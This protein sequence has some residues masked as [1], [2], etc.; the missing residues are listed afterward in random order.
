M[1]QSSG[2]FSG[3]YTQYGAGG[4]GYFGA[5]ANSTGTFLYNP[6]RRGLNDRSFYWSPSAVF[7]FNIP[8]TGATGGQFEL[9]SVDTYDFGVTPDLGWYITEDLFKPYN[10]LEPTKSNSS[11]ILKTDLS[12]S[13]GNITYDTGSRQLYIT[14]SEDDMQ[15]LVYLNYGASLWSIRGKTTNGIYTQWISPKRFTSYYQLPES[16]I[17]VNNPI[18][19]THDRTVMLYGSKHD[20]INTVV[21]NG[22]TGLTRYP[23]QSAWQYD[24]VL[25]GGINTFFIKGISKGIETPYIYSK[26][27]LETGSINQH[28]VFNTFDDFGLT[29][30]LERIPYESNYSYKTRIKDVFN[31]PSDSNLLGLTNG[32]VRNLNLSYD[33]EALIIK[34]NQV[35]G[36]F[37]D[38]LYPNLSIT[39]DTNTIYIGSTA[40]KRYNEYH[41]VDPQDNS[42]TLTYTTNYIGI[43]SL[44]VYSSPD[45]VIAKDR[46]TVENNI[47]KLNEYVP[48]IWVTY[49]N[50]FEIS[51]LNKTVYQ[52]YT[53]LAAF[54][55]EDRQIFNI[56]TGYLSGSADGLL[57]STYEIRS[58]ARYI[59]ENEIEQYGVP[60]KWA[61]VCINKLTDTGY[62]N[63]YTGEFGDLLNSKIESFV[64]LFKNKSHIA[65]D[66]VVC[67]S[68][69]FDPIDEATESSSYI[70]SIMDPVKGFWKSTN[71]LDSNKI[72]TTKAV[73]MNFICDKDK[74]KLEY[75]GIKPSQFKSGIGDNDDLKV[76][77]NTYT[78]KEDILKPDIFRATVAKNA[79]GQI[80]EASYLPE[81]VW[82]S[83]LFES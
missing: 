14:L 76:V 60:I 65:F 30:G 19:T 55:Y 51:K 68:D 17:T 39:I 42:V 13:N 24:T 74:T 38:E 15:K 62:Q 26:V 45:S 41:K 18:Y 34:P 37:T 47:I 46:Y 49:N 27:T 43:N 57:K 80:N 63:R 12:V 33:D 59:D 66:T 1:S 64:I 79:T 67:D 83:I 56:Q 28:K 9:S 11:L 31:H 8:N 54:S 32:I 53:G 44:I 52:V 25:S 4:Y 70:P 3:Q 20:S 50:T 78:I 71:P 82:G 73:E 72:S 48:E 75:Y 40:F 5:P 36:R 7:E 29:V 16:Y 21:I 10:P 58:T 81:T 77:L 6:S 2:Q 22:M 61:D 35:D 23:S 69:V